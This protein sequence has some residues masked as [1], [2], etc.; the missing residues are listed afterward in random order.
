MSEQKERRGMR[1]AIA[2]IGTRTDRAG[3]ANPEILEVVI[4]EQ[5]KKESE[6]R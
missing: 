1:H 5:M 4:E 2:A 3:T 6:A